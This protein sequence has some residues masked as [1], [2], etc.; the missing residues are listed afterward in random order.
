VLRVSFIGLGEQGKPIAVN[1]AKAGCDLMVHDLRVEP[2]RELAAL[3]AQVAMSARDAGAYGDVIEIIVVN[4]AQVEA[5]VFGDDGVLAGARPASLIA[6]HST[7]RPATVRKVAQAAAAKGVGVVNAPVSGGARGAETRTLCYTVGG[8]KEAV[9]RCRPLF[10]TSGNNILHFG[11]LG[12]GMAAK[13]ARQ[14]IICLNVL[15]AHEGMIIAEKAGLDLTLMQEAIRAGG[16]SSR[17]AD[18]WV[19][20]RPTPQAGALWYKDLALALEYAHEL[21]AILPGAALTQQMLEKLLAPLAKTK[22]ETT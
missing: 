21:G 20:Y 5:V 17:I 16:A 10:E 4:D 12:A 11:P 9:D 6:L 18:H 13:L 8:E 1:L 14:V 2:V 7:I 15:A 19:K 22:A 3:G